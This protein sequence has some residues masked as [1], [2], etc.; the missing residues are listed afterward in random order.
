LKRREV[1]GMIV[2]RK[3]ENGEKKK[4]N[5]FPALTDSARKMGGRQLF[6]ATELLQGS[7]SEKK[8]ERKRKGGGITIVR[9]CFVRH[10]RNVPKTGEEGGKKKGKRKGKSNVG[11]L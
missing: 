9:I 2:H 4:K 1:A 8:N 11:V 7:Y 6:L 5:F 10:G 3:G